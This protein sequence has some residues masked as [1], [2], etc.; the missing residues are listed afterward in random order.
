[1]EMLQLNDLL[2]KE[3][4]EEYW[5]ILGD[6]HEELPDD[7]DYVI[8]EHY[9]TNPACDCKTLLADIQEIGVDG[10]AIK[11]SAV[12]I[13]YNWSSKQTAC[14]PTFNDKSPKTKTAINLLAVYKKHVHNT[15]YLDKIKSEYARMKVLALKKQTEKTA[16]SKKNIGR[17]DPCH[18]GSNKKYKKCCLTT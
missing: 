11:K 5:T 1:M 14:V 9:C 13:D 17:N 16:Y 3:Q 8:F 12:I 7:K 10:R 6:Q 15:E 2:P 4:W 18:C